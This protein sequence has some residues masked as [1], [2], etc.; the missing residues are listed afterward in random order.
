[1]A[2]LERDI[3]RR[4]GQ[5]ISALNLGSPQQHFV[6]DLIFEQPHGSPPLGH[7]A[8]LLDGVGHISVPPA[9]MLQS[10]VPTHSLID[11]FMHPFI[12]VY[13][14]SM[15]HSL[16]HSFIH[17]LGHSFVHAS[18]CVFIDESFI[19]PL[20]H[21]RMCSSRRSFTQHETQVSIFLSV[22]LCGQ[23]I[24]RRI[25]TIIQGFHT[26]LTGWVS[27]CKPCLLCMQ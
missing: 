5:H 18:V 23:Q 16:I 13:M 27:R 6:Q 2:N 20:T 19:H 9:V 14:H 12:H 21:T 8:P 7:V 10:A 3:P 15:N 1:M 26:Y 24:N 4:K 11:S 22:S 17:A 25:G